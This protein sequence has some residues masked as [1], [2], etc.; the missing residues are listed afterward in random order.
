[1]RKPFERWTSFRRSPSMTEGK[2]DFMIA[3]QPVTIAK[4]RSLHLRV[5]SCLKARALISN[6]GAEC[7]YGARLNGDLRSGELIPNINLRED[8]L[9]TIPKLPIELLDAIIASPGNLVDRNGA[10]GWLVLEIKRKRNRN[11]AT[12]L[13]DSHVD[14]TG[15]RCICDFQC[16]GAILVR[17]VRASDTINGDGG[18]RDNNLLAA[19]GSEESTNGIVEVP[20][21][22]VGDVKSALD[23]VS[24]DPAS[25]SSH[26]EASGRVKPRVYV[27]CPLASAIATPLS[28]EL[29]QASR[30]SSR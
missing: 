7:L 22:T 25:V 9:I 1:M 8:L 11:T 26:N 13:E 30:P 5:S 12:L 16:F 28:W 29:Q 23:Q 6:N 20:C 27:T 21:T 4:S 3:C 17:T 14:L 19:T 18:W 2:I 15:R 10:H 24:C